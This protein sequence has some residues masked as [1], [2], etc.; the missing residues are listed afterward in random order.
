MQQ[1]IKS[2]PLNKEIKNRQRRTAK[3]AGLISFTA[4]IVIFLPFQS[5]SGMQ[6]IYAITFVAFFLFIASVLVTVIFRS[7]SRKMDKL[8]SGIELIAGW[9]LNDEE[10]KAYVN[11]LFITEKGKNGGL[12][13][14]ITLFM[15]LFFGLFIVFMEEGKWAM[16]L[17]FVGITAVIALFAFGMPYY[18]RFRN[19]RGD[20][21][22]LIGKKYAYVNGTF[23]NWDFPLSGLVKAK[24]IQ[25]PFYGM[26]LHYY[27]Y[28]R[29][30]RNEE[31][32][33]IPASKNIDM[34][35]ITEKLKASNNYGCI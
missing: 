6:G 9:K 18:Y 34:K 10:K 3:T 23:H 20:G 12:F 15:V 26:L 31:V 7:R 35:E 1:Q 28:D 27:Y 13:F 16:F 24:V 32:L 11:H 8:I 33:K 2:N 29:T 22:V 14:V 5:W 19:N 4:V 21:Y 30:L 17:F 25:K